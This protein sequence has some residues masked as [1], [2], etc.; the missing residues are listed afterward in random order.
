M[1]ALAVDITL[2]WEIDGERFLAKDG[3]TESVV[4]DG[5]EENADLTRLTKKIP[6][7]W[8][9]EQHVQEDL[10]W[11]PSAADWLRQIK[12]QPWMNRPQRLSRELNQEA[13]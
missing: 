11:I 6:T 3:F 4:R 7:R 10:G 9:G 1:L 2:G 8:V 13:S 5:C 12:P